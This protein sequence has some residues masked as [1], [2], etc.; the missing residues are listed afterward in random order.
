LGLTFPGKG[1]IQGPLLAHRGRQG[2]GDLFPTCGGHQGEDLFRGPFAP[3]VFKRWNNERIFYD[4]RREYA[5]ISLMNLS[6][7]VDL[8]SAAIPTVSNGFLPAEIY[9]LYI[10]FFDILY[11]IH[12]FQPSSGTGL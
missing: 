3:E 8:G 11:N 10:F 2:G 9:L 6:F 7:G 5:N 12:A 1:Q 4:K